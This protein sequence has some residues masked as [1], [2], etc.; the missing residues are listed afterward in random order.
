MT[1]AQNYDSATLPV[2][3]SGSSEDLASGD[4]LGA[5]AHHD[6]CQVVGGPA[7]KFESLRYKFGPT[8]NRDRPSAR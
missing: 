7:A 5:D 1:T 6:L 8:R 4:L 3:R 2:C